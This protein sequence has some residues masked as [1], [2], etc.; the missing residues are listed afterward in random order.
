MVYVP[1]LSDDP[2]EKEVDVGVTVCPELSVAVGVAQVTTVLEEP[3]GT[4]T[5]WLAGQVS[6][7]AVASTNI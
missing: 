5:A 4:V 3:D 7:G 1:A 2:E 6:T